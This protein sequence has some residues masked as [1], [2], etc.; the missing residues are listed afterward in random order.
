MRSLADHLKD[1]KTALLAL[2][3][4]GED[5]FEGLVGTALQ[6]ISG[7]P[8]R[9]AGSGRQ[10]GI[11]GKPAYDEDCVCFEAKR[12][13]GKIDRRDLIVK[14][15]D[16][17]RNNTHPDLVWVLGATTKVK[18][19]D[20]DDLRADGRSRGIGVLILDWSDDSVSPLAAALTA[21][22][23]RVET[24]LKKSLGDAGLI[25]GALSAFDAIKHHK[26]FEA[27]VRRIRPALD[28]PAM[29]TALA[30]EA[31]ARW[32]ESVFSDE[33]RAR[34]ELGQ[35]LSPA[36]STA[37]VLPRESLSGKLLPFLSAPPDGKVTFVLG[38]EGCGK[39]WIVAQCWLR[40]EQK[41]LMI[42]LS[43]EEFHGAVS[44]NDLEALLIA[45]LV[46]QTGDELSEISRERWRRRIA[47]WRLPGAVDRPRLV[48]M[49]DGI[50][51]RPE[52][53]WGR[54]IDRIDFWL[55]E[56]RCRLVVT[57][58]T[59][60]FQ[61]RVKSRFTGKGTEIRVAEWTDAERDEILSAHEIDPKTLNTAVARTLRNPRLLGIAL[62]LLGKNAIAALD[63]LTVSRLLFEHIRTSEQDAPSPQPADAFAGRLQDH[64][65]RILDRVKEKRE[66]DLNIFEAD[67]PAV[68]DGRFFH[69]VAGEP[70]KYELKEDGLTLALG[71]SVVGHL[72]AAKRNSRDL[73]DA[74]AV[75]IEPISGLDDTADVI[76][77]ALTVISADDESY[78]S[79]IAAAL[80]KGFAG[81]QNP[82]PEKFPAFAGLAR[83]RPQGFLDATRALCLGGGHE[84]NFD[85]IEA[86]VASAATDARAWEQI[87]GEIR[88]WLS[89]H[90]L[91]PEL[92]MLPRPGRGL[93]QEVEKD[94]ADHQSALEEKLGALS[95]AERD[96]L[97]NL[98]EADGDISALSR[99]AMILLA[100][101]PLAPFAESLRN[102]S[103]A[104]ALNSDYAA[105]YKEL[106]D[107][108]S[109][110]LTDWRE[111]RDALLKISQPLRGPEVSKTGKW[112]LVSIL[113][114][115]G[116]P[117][118][119]AQACALARELNK[120]RPRPG[121]Y[122]LIED[123]CAT[124]P[125]DPGSLEPDN[126]NATAAKYEAIE[127]GK[128]RQSMGQG[129]ED[130]FFVDA[131]PGMAR[132]CADVAIE[133]HRELA[134]DV[135]TRASFP[136]RQGLLELHPNNATL[137]E[138]QASALIDNWRT[139][140][141]EGKLSGLSEQDV[142]VVSQYHLLLAFPFMS[143]SGQ[144]EILLTVDENEP[145][146]L[147]L[148]DVVAAP[149]QAAFDR[150]LDAARADDN[151]YRQSLLLNIARSTGAS[152]SAGA[153]EFVVQSVRS[154]S[155]ALRAQALGVIA[156]STD[157]AMLTEVAESGWNA[158][159]GHTDNGFEIHYGSA[160][161]L[162][163]A[164]EG[165]MDQRDA[166]ARI[167]PQLFGLAATM[168][169]EDTVREIA[170]RIDASITQAAG[171][172]GN[173]VVPD[174]DLDVGG[175]RR[176][177][178]DRFSVREREPEP[179]DFAEA[180]GRLA[181]SGRDL[182]ESQRRSREAF[183]E[184]RRTLTQ[185][186]ARIILERL[187]LDEF[188][189]IVAADKEMADKWFE[190]FIDLPKSR[191]PVLHNLILLLA[192]SL[193]DNEP[194][195]A[196]ALFV[197]VRDSRPIV[198]FVFGR[199]GVELDAMATWAGTD[200]ETLN[201]LRFRRLDRAGTDHE[202]SLEVLAALLNGK[203][204]Q[205]GRYVEDKTGCKEPAQIARG[206]MV[207]G[208]ANESALNS[209]IIAKYEGL[210]GFLGATGKSAR[211]AYERNQW[212]RQWFAR[213][214]KAED[215]EEFWRC[216][217]LFN[218]IID[219]RFSTWRGEYEQPG[220]AIAVFGPSAGSR[221]K[222]RYDRWAQ[223]RK[224]T[225]CGREVPA[226]AFLASRAADGG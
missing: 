82:D 45:K 215:A 50:N 144:A 164:T 136:L 174:I 177:E 40:L 180:M 70:D 60:Y 171:L 123:F 216:Q 173:L 92:R 209:G 102:W 83:S 120:D 186:K 62:R 198:R 179:A 42:V 114:A 221:L 31:N 160:A 220:A 165:V 139:A 212:A 77:A 88:R 193:G 128:L 15:A 13:D 204:E 8:F 181:S 187:G 118:D 133:K 163:A 169:G 225:L 58:R 161:L 176:Y 4:I 26:D 30:R 152:L 43:A 131:R 85:W 199:A 184:F 154:G 56:I 37:T 219:G 213:M 57:S 59:N 157:R 81:L 196:E 12:Y 148:M 22:G 78:V 64:A 191:L 100:G 132:F 69:P 134:D 6:E 217:V 218:K 67:T 11:D 202:L 124:D 16:L 61:T 54:I 189:A 17:A 158:A 63:E 29:G 168:L 208:F 25:K 3:A 41:P 71:F 91:S 105:P 153:R 38:D 55:G 203:Q 48:V 1:L 205:L 222:N 188:R 94:R 145:I 36:V 182:E 178:P 127:V 74:L 194:D 95:P 125:C 65:G 207:A 35:P 68:A 87:S 44:R 224:K 142:W 18:T 10:F 200:N 172:D 226:Q 93:A 66:G 206:I 162:A 126:I 211:Y 34:I 47:Q 19:Q 170:R 121:R 5:G 175:E 110:S 86:A 108:V 75:L 140:K 104:S 103:F 113:R 72:L 23:E 183:R 76:M 33:R 9:L 130:H 112:A 137:T 210:A 109:L 46:E 115:T 119:A 141:A 159:D 53:D 51:Q 214:C 39:S 90:S 96:I 14:I 201:R 150:L 32:L 101:K 107:L 20:A 149:D 52:I 27:H 99:L 143:A 21:G 7:V 84:P 80:V 97:G 147:D 116:N 2:K 73:D 111:A 89:V 98:P 146:L 28:A 167:A 138:A 166:V 190:L 135:L 49:I 117:D 185:A 195:K 155:E 106:G 156:Q 151:E 129:S 223:K 192:H 197:R 122:R 79:E 24:F